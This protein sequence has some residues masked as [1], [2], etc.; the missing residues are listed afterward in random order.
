MIQP[1]DSNKKYP[2]I[3]AKVLA[4]SISPA[5]D[6]MI[7]YE[8]Q[9][10]RIV[11]AEFMT[12]RMLS[13]NASSSRAVPFKSV[14]E[15][16]RADV[17]RPTHWGKNQA[18]M[19]AFEEHD[20]LINGYTA[21]EW[22]D[23]AAESALAFSQGFADA[24]YHKQVFNRISEPFTYMRAVVSGT[25]W[26]NFFHLRIHEMADHTLYTLAHCIYQARISSKPKL[27]HPG[28]WHLPYYK[29]GY[30]SELEDGKDSHGH[31]IQEALMISASCCAQVSYRKLDDSMEKAVNVFDKLNIDNDSDDPCHASPTEHQA[32]PMY[33]NEWQFDQFEVESWEDGVTHMD[34]NFKLWSGNLC[35]WVQYRQTIKGHNCTYYIPHS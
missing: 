21:D 20:E 26:D 29:D 4:H 22:W 13:K 19:Q 17:A 31:T 2:T 6:E 33:Y 7:T 14:A 5:G 35:G 23:L 9:V 10:P 11:W 3:Y 1:V 8:I 34:R 30:W 27:L 24:G 16:I 18:G 25:E 12:H 15:A 32:T 28:E